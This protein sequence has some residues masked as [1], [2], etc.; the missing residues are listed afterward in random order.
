MSEGSKWTPT[1]IFLLVI[2]ILAGLGILCCGGGW[3]MWGDKIMSG[4]HFGTNSGEFVRRLQADYG[5]T[6]VFGIEKNDKVEFILTIGVEGELTPERVRTV[7]D[8]AWK[9]FGDVY[10]KDGFFPVKH[11][12]VGRPM[13]NSAGQGGAVVDWSANMVST[14]E[15]AKRT[16]VAAPPMVKFL[17]EDFANGRFKV[18]VSST[19]DTKDDATDEK[20]GKE[21]DGGGG[22]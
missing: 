9:T 14:E 3:L 18:S 5:K 21:G 13:K 17:P 19:D 1:K 22:K 8:G 2:G 6:A 15:L 11:L 4:I 20:K 12:A 10:G 7:Q 16:G